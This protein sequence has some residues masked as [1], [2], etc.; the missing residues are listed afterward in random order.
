MEEGATLSMGDACTVNM[1]GYMA[2]ADGKTKGDPLPNTASGDNVE[3]VLGDGLYMEGLVEGI[4]GAKVGDS[5]TVYVAF[6][7]VSILF[8][9]YASGILFVL[10][11]FSSSSC[12]PSLTLSLILHHTPMHTKNRN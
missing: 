6:P 11:C 10:L 2:E 5:R 3:I 8:V 4:V 1:V 9:P 7:D 12:L